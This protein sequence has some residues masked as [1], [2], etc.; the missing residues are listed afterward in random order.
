M[1]IWGG[2][3]GIVD[4][5]EKESSYLYTGAFVV[6]MIKCLSFASK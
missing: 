1:S 3:D 5:L 4:R 6:V 2:G